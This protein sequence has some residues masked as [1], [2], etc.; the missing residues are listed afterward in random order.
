MVVRWLVLKLE[1]IIFYLNEQYFDK[2]IVVSK[3]ITNNDISSQIKRF[4]INDKYLSID[5]RLW[6]QIIFPYN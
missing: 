5:K 3:V 2:Q 4:L 1:C 6:N